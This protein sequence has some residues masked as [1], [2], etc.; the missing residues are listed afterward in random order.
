MTWMDLSDGALANTAERGVLELENCALWPCE[1]HWFE[2]IGNPGLQ[3]LC[4]DNPS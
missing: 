1:L 2:Y 4:L 3:R